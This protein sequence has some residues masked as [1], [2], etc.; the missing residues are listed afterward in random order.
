MGPGLDV[1]R[2]AA[3]TAPAP[4]DARNVRRPTERPACFTRHYHPEPRRSRFAA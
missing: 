3:A 4:T 1:D 2:H